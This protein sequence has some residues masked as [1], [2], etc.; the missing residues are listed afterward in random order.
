MTQLILKIRLLLPLPLKNDKEALARVTSRGVIKSEH[1]K[2]PAVDTPWK[3]HRRC[4]QDLNNPLFS[5]TAILIYYKIL[6]QFKVS[7][8]FNICS[9]VL[10][11]TEFTRLQ[12]KIENN[13][14][15]CL[16]D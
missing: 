8:I 11:F 14:L 9:C 12:N 13:P 10:Y 1:L 5:A 6:H 2:T 15:H 4:R 3:H 16:L 7:V